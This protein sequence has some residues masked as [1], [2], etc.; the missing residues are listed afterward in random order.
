MCSLSSILETGDG[1]LRYCLSATACAGILRR[2]ATRGKPLPGF[3]EAALWS[4][5]LKH[6]GKRMCELV[7]A[8]LDQFEAKG[9]RLALPTLCR[10]VADAM[11]GGRAL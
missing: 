10:Y 9:Q 5:V 8:D 2:A 11:E 7:D 3:L 4:V 6:L 1:P